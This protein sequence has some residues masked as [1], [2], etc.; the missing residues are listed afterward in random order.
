MQPAVRYSPRVETASPDET[1]TIRDL[2]DVLQDIMQVTAKE[3]G[4]A[5]RSVHAKSH[6]IIRAELDVLDGLPDELAQGL[7]AVPGRYPAILRLSTNPGDI[8]H[9]SISVPRGVGLKIMHVS[10]ERLPGAEGETQDFV[11]V[12]GPIFT[13]ADP[14]A[15]LKNLKLL[16]KTTE[17]AEW[18]KRALSA[19]LRGTERALE[20]VGLESGT[21]KS[22]GGAPNVHPL[23]ETYYSQTPFRY[24]NYI[25]KFSLVP[26]SATLTQHSGEIVDTKGK[27]DAIGQAVDDAMRAGQA[28]WELRVQLCRDLD[29]MPVEDPTK[30]WDEDISPYFAVARLTANPQSTASDDHVENEMRFSPWTG[31]AAHRPLG[32]I[33]RARRDAYLASAEYRAAFNGCPIHEPSGTDT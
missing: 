32:A 15:F 28:V 18:A 31:L 33:N 24:G 2:I 11:M 8:L 12:N 20:T 16:S 25:A 26:I 30:R 6:G 27:P 3:Y 17:R 7:F 9:D 22:L 5:V 1:D 14:A 21:I 4:H 10:G 23:G 29:Q 13:T 19:V